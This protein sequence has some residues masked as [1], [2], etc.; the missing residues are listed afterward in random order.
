M[1][2]KINAISFSLFSNTEYLYLLKKLNISVSQTGNKSL[3]LRVVSSSVKRKRKGISV[4]LDKIF[5][6]SVPPFYSPV[7]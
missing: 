2:F 3:M 1:S 6:L 4:I 5:K 7:K